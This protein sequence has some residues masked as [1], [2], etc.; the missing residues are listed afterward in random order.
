MAITL[1]YFT[2][3]FSAFAGVALMAAMVPLNSQISQR[4][5]VIQIEVKAASDRRI[6]SSTDLQTVD[7]HLAVL[8]IATLH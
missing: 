7:Q 4:F 8:T 6:Q 3:G 5:G 1:L 2:L